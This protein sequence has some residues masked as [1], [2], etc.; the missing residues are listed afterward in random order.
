MA[1]TK[2]LIVYVVTFMLTTVS[3]RNNLKAAVSRDLSRALFSGLT[4]TPMTLSPVVFCAVRL[5]PDGC[6]L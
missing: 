1:C 3:D 5:D 4:H 2:L 6:V